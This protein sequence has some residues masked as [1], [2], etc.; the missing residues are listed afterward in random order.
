MAAVLL[1]L[2]VTL[3]PSALAFGPEPTRTAVELDELQET[4]PIP[5]AEKPTTE[6]QQLSGDGSTGKGAEYDPAAVAAV[7][8]AS[9]TKAVTDLAPGTT[10]PVAASADGTVSVAVGAPE[11]ATPAQADALEGEWTVAVP[12]ES[13]AVGSGA[14]GL[15]LAVDAPDTATGQAVVSIDATRFAEAYNAE[16]LDRLSFNLMPACFA[17][18]PEL[19]ECSQGVPVT[20][21]VELTGDKVTVP[22]D[23]GDSS[24]SEADPG[25]DTAADELDGSTATTAQV[26]ETLVNVTLDTAALKAVSA[27]GGSSTTTPAVASGDGTTSSAL[28]R[29]DRGPSRV[30]QVADAAGGAYMVGGSHGAGQS[31]D[32]AATPLA[33]GGDWSSGGSSGAFSYAY[34]MAGPQVPSGPSPNVT[35]SYNSQSSDGRTSATNNQ[36]SWIGEGWDYHPGSITRTFVTCAADTANANNEKHFTGD[37]CWGTYNAVLSLN[38]T[39]T[40]LVRDDTSKEWKSARGDN[41]RIEL[42]DTAEYQRILNVTHGPGNED[43]NGEFW[44]VTTSDGTQYYFGLNRLPGWSSGKPE[45][46]SVLTVPVAGNHSSDPCH[47][48]AFKDSFCDQ[49]WRFQLD[50]V[51]D[52]T[53]NAMSLWWDREHNAY[54]QNNKEASAV[55][56]HRAGLLRRIDYGQRAESLFTQEPLGRMVFTTQERCFSDNAFK[57]ACSDGNFDSKQSH[58][59][60]PW[61]DTPADLACRAGKKCTNYAPTFWSRQRLSK[62]TA[63]AQREQGVR[64][65]EYS[66]DG[67]GTESG[68]PHAC[69]LAGDGVSTT[70]LSKVDAWDLTQSFPHGLT[71][72]YTALWLDSI[73]RTGYGVDGTTERLNPVSFGYGTEPLPN[74]VREGAADT[75]PLFGRLRIRDV[76]SEYGGRTHVEYKAPEGACATGTGFP[77]VD[78]NKLRCYPVHWHA[79]GELTDKHLSWFHKYVVYK[80]T[81]IP[82]LA[83]AK[84]LTTTY[85][86]DTFSDAHD[87]AL[88]AKNNAEFS[89]PKTRTWDQWRGYP[90]VT[91]TTGGDATDGSAASK[92]VTRYYRGMSDDV[93]QDG[94]PKNPADDV[95]RSYTMTDVTGAALKPDR[96]AYA[97]MVAESLTYL[98][99]SDAT[100]T[101]WISRT[102]NVPDDPVRLATRNRTDA[103]DVVAER[104]TLD[105]TRTITKSSGTGDDP[106]TLRTVTTQ[107][108]YDEYGLPT[109]VREHGD[110]AKSGDESCT[111]TQYVHHTGRDVYLVGL[112]AQTVTTTGTTGTTACTAELSTATQDTLVSASRVY[113]DNATSHTAT[114][115]QG[116]VTK[117]VI[118]TE[119]GTGWQ[120]THPESQTKYD[121]TGRI[122]E[123]TDATGLVNKT[124]YKPSAGQVFTIETVAGS[125]LDANGAETGFTS[126]TTLEPG[127]G[128]TLTTRDPNGRVSSYTYDALGRTTA[129]WDA[130]QNPTDDPTA[131]YEYNTDPKHPVSVVTQALSDNPSTSSGDGVYTS[132][133]TIYDGL[134]RERQTQAP[135]VGGGRLVTD[136]FH[137]AAGQVRF[138]RNA[139]YMDGDPETGLVVPLS[140]SMVPNAT[141]YT[142]DGLGRV[143]TVTP[144]HH[145]YPQTGAT[146]TNGDGQ[147][148]PTTDR[149]TRYE[150]GL[151]YTVVRQPKGTPPS[152]VWTDA[153]GRTVRQD[154]FSDTSLAE[155]SAITTRYSYDVRGDLVTTTDDAGHTRTWKYNA[156]GGVTD[157]TDPDAGAAHTTYDAMGRVA[158]AVTPKGDTT[159]YGY[160]RFSRV[161]EVKVT[162][163]G[164]TTATVAQT[165]AYDTATGGK[166]RLAQATRYTDGKPY[167][168]SIAGYTADY[169]PTGMTVALPP[170]STPGL[171]TD[172]FSTQYPYTYKYDKD[173]QL[174]SY[175]APA[176]GGLTAEDVITRYNKSGLP[177]SVSGKDWY[178][179]ETDYSVYGQVLR[180]TVGEQGRRV[181]QD[182]TYDEATGELLRSTLVREHI[183]DTQVVPEHRINTRSYAYDPSGNVLNVADASGNGTT[184]RQ[185]FT[186]DT[187]GQLTEAWTTPSGRA[188]AAPGKTTAE[189]VYTDGTVNVSANNY[190]Y[191]QSYSY[192]TLGNRTQ[193]VNHKAT[194]TFGTDGKVDTKGDV[195]TDYDYGTSLT[196]K[197]DQPHTLT[198][199]ATTSTTAQGAAVTTRSTQTYDAAG[200]LETRTNGGVTS[201][202]LTWTWDGKVESVT[203][204]GPDGAGPWTGTADLCLDLSSSSTAAG[205]PVQIWRCNGT[206]AQNFRLEPADTTGDGQVD[207]A[208]I[209]QFK[210]ADRCVQPAVKPAAIGTALGI[211]ACDPDLSAQRWETLTTGQLKHVDSKL[212]LSAPATTAG[213]DLVLAS[214]DQTAI[215]QLWK[216]GSK[217]TYVYDAFGNRLLERSTSGAVL[218]LPDTKVALTTSGSLRYAERSYGHG[219]A[220]SVIRYREGNGTGASEQLFAQAVDINGTPMAEVRLDTA[221]EAF[222]RLNRKDPWGEDRGAN[223]SPRSHT[224]FHTG[225]DD[226]ATGFVHLGAREYDPSTGRFISVDPVLDQSDPLQANGYSY[227]NNNPVTHA[228]PSGLTSTATNFDASIAALDKQ[229]AAY[230]KIL[231]RSLGDVILATGWA[232]FKEF[233]GWNDVVGC[234]SQGDLWACGSLLMDAIPWTSI[235]SKGKKMWGAFKAT[236]S[237]VKAFKAAKAAAEAGIKAAKAARAALVRAKKAAEAAAAEA[238]RKARE[239]AKAAAAAAKK[240]AHTGSK[241]ARGN[242]PQVQARKTSQAKGNA[243]GGRA[244]SKSGGSRGGSGRDDSGSDRGGSGESC[245]VSNSFTPQTKVLMADGTT[246]AIKDVKAGD[247]VLATDP[248]TGETRVETVTAEIKGDGVKHLVKVTVDTDGKKGSKTAGITATDGHP[249]W[250]PALRKW[251]KAT[252]LR[253]GQWLRNGAGTL[254]QITAIDRWTVQRTT[255][256]NLTVSDL[257]TYYVLADATPVL[258]HNCGKKISN[259]ALGTSDHGLEKFANDNGYTHFMGDSQ[260]DALANVH[261]AVNYHDEA[262]IHVRLDGFKMTSGKPGTPTELFDDAVREGQGDNWYT[263]QREMAILER[264]FRLGNIDASRLT[265]YMADKDITEEIV[266]G[267]K[268]LGGS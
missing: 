250:V 201:Q 245:D 182:S 141:T 70:L 117:T 81:E 251:V 134:G 136:T 119:N 93:L 3:L 202:T 145:S 8:E 1:G 247:K 59:T 217:T 42:L 175:R 143:L 257:H 115:T 186:Y 240:K 249:F 189:P 53:G 109:V 227:A 52:P 14:Q 233:V 139:Y 61:F 150:Y 263:T 260:E 46:D 83:D 152:R 125:K 163:K 95:K 71:G 224:A 37:Q 199:Y 265:F 231:N 89:R 35:L 17:T 108:D 18:T 164:S 159:A 239:A 39:T 12:P 79:D 44:R 32:F 129:V 22:L 252:D 80:I 185:C 51:V 25:E 195:V 47:A 101:G 254:V 78:Q 174:E 26:P 197:N 207:N 28:W 30:M 63:C 170:G 218:H 149:R 147:Q 194:P 99:T 167:T 216:P 146:A 177:V 92:T 228:D 76:I 191:W 225:D 41:M 86:Y 156:L 193:K 204:F 72:D 2:N 130:T 135:A 192:D 196:A 246:K 73:T 213:T 255:V 244:E 123:V 120:T 266:S 151:D 9:G 96:Q 114:P 153:V 211:Q 50:Y 90:I 121:S 237:A 161:T 258:V 138:T 157:T 4:D 45:T 34:T 222:V 155:D 10:T 124:V 162:P 209:G 87:G 234:F 118:P 176:A 221:G 184:D 160:D 168:T 40:E 206:K 259:V 21:E 178:V 56:Y 77:P 179:A 142:Y 11:G 19:E 54:A 23:A 106:S 60:R 158:T 111:R 113:Y 242:T 102:V 97:G 236:M 268:Y 15:M 126:T 68:S 180:S 183:G 91:T 7:P 144:V 248:K 66:T 171:T 57:V 62:V 105:T 215:G 226:A 148:V 181:W 103:P 140:E 128:T 38:G 69:G 100:S 173:G 169:Q 267:S 49:G 243:G 230:Q 24:G 232:V 200:N 220:P 172:G 31:G 104:V 65:T 188:C 238:K 127:R 13:Q 165:Y 5:V 98:S 16:W 261:D 203:G 241:G 94:T 27:A 43:D 112:V 6:L 122:T 262:H 132:A 223:L 33:T 88:W 166:G 74:R 229:I 198:S 212:C 58:L 110:T 64:L 235:I 154:T 133:T 219:G 36:V 256:H 75:G 20:T 187:L 205:N 214:C 55:G 190:G 82:R 85:S 48:T 210:V 116:Q 208:N 84:D 67:N 264:A 131:R 29:G 107:T 137:N 253:A